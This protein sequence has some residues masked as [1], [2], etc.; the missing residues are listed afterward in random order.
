MNY[1]KNNLDIQ[2]ASARIGNNFDLVLI[3]AMRARELY[4]KKINTSHKY[5]VEALKNIQDGKVGK[6]LL[7]R[8]KRRYK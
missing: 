7:Y 3:A 4:R 1:I 2:L 8:M 5:T 6:E